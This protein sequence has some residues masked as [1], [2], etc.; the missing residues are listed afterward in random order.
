M[1]IPFS[2]VFFSSGVV[3]MLLYLATVTKADFYE[4]VAEYDQCDEA[5][6]CRL[7]YD[8]QDLLCRC[9]RYC[10][11]YGDCCNELNITSTDPS[12]LEGL[13]EC[14]STHLDNRT[15]P[16]YRESFWMVSKCPQ[17]W[18]E[19][20]KD[21]F[22]QDVFNSCFNG[23]D[24]L[25]PVTDLLTGLV[26][27][28]EFCAICHRVERF[29]QWGY[30][31]FCSPEAQDILIQP[32]F[33]F[34]FDLLNEECLVCGFIEPVLSTQEI[35]R[36]CFHHSLVTDH[37]LDHENLEIETRVPISDEDYQDIVGRCKS[38]PLNPLISR[39]ATTPYR[40]QYCVMC[41]GVL[42]SSGSLTCVN[43]YDYR[44]TIDYCEDNVSLPEMQ[45]GAPVFPSFT[46]F[47]DVDR[48]TQT[49]TVAHRTFNI[50]QTCSEGE[51]FDLVIEGCRKTIC[52]DVAIGKSCTIIDQGSGDN[53]VYCDAG[54][55]VALNDSEFTPINNSSLL[56]YGDIIYD[57][58]GYINESAVIC[59]NFS[60]NGT[61]EVN[62]TSVQF[63][64]PIA[65]AVISYVGCSLSVL[66][67]GIVLMTHFIFKDLQT[68]PGK[69]LMNL[70]AAILATSLFFILAGFPIFDVTIVDELCQ[71]V[72]IILHWL[73]LT[74]FSW[75]TVMSCELARTMLRA[76]RLEQM[77]NA[78]IKQR[79]FLVY[80]LIGWG[81][82]TL[83]SIVT[84]VVNYTTE[85]V[86]Y[87]ESGFCWIGNYYSTYV[88]FI[89]P[90]V[91][92]VT[93]NTIAFL[94]T[95]YLLIKAQ[96]SQSKLRGS[97]SISY[98]RIHL[99]VFSVTGLTWVFGVFANFTEGT[100]AWYLFIILSTT[101]GFTICAAFVFTRKVLN[102]YRNLFWPKIS[103]KLS[104]MKLQKRSTQNSSLSKDRGESCING[105]VAEND[106]K[107]SDLSEDGY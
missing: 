3:V 27:K 24:D 4:A 54:V 76:S 78:S 87:G 96:R 9:D 100:W 26:Y 42:V 31:L 89:T 49:V 53:S 72:A 107:T 17:E 8:E 55:P 34:T 48:N 83:V 18:L 21:P 59:V 43:P 85:Y 12:P 20:V 92:S 64:H 62:T 90:V 40:N 46:I 33:E 16:A 22:V 10:T 19:G 6:H 105:A 35:A 91:I 75:M 41:T 51:V 39:D 14:R 80:L 103:R 29:T 11:T 52:Q 94:I 56:Y 30:K 1:K 15:I 50:S 65:F 28:N 57:I 88:T 63:S 77:E 5:H 79:I 45:G 86:Q 67:C 47:I 101:Q 73:V 7:Y 98:L 104:F 102:L 93:I 58:V 70:S 37:C 68:L 2:R 60:Q 106:N 23:S 95:S 84:I 32:E 81:I 13:L 44:D 38:G 66:G 99:S 82:P 25:P 71:V 36:P 97:N 69:I 61:S 74:E